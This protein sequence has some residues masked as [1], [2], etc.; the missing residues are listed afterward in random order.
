MSFPLGSI[1][2]WKAFKSTR[3]NSRPKPRYL[4][5]GEVAFLGEFY[6]IFGTTTAKVDFYTEGN[7][8]GHEYLIFE[9]DHPCF[10]RKCVLSQYDFHW[11]TRAE[12]L[13]ALREERIFC[14]CSLSPRE[15]EV[16]AS[17]LI[18][19]GDIPEVFKPSLLEAWENQKENEILRTLAGRL[20][21][22]LGWKQKR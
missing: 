16:S 19:H 11:K 2:Y 20:A 6:C 18:Q 7:R 1:L 13:E 9:E 14:K 17:L 12:V 22:F 10:S 15:L 3:I 5:F 21:K 8:Q 4:Y